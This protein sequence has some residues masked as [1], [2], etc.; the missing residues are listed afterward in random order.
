MTKPFDRLNL[1]ALLG[2]FTNIIG[3]VHCTKI[4]LSESYCHLL[5]TSVTIIYLKAYAPY[6]ANAVPETLR[7]DRPSA[8]LT[9]M[10]T[11]TAL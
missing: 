10:G 8:L 1:Q 7:V 4:P 5:M 3:N 2:E 9:I 11:G 6:Q